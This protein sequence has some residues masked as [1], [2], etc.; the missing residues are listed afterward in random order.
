MNAYV[1]VNLI[2]IR[3]RSRQPPGPLQDCMFRIYLLFF[4]S[5]VVLLT[6]ALF[7]RPITAFVATWCIYLSTRNIVIGMHIVEI[8]LA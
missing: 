1:V 2:T 7:P 8:Q 3:S 5:L 4:F 6:F